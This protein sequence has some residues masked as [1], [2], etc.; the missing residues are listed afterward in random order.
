[1]HPRDA[2]PRR[3]RG[4][5]DVGRTDR[6]RRSRRAGFGTAAAAPPVASLPAAWPPNEFVR[7]RRVSESRR[8][9]GPI[10]VERLKNR[11]RRRRRRGGDEGAPSER[12]RN[13]AQAGGS[14]SSDLVGVGEH[15]LEGAVSDHPHLVVAVVLAAGEE[16]EA[17]GGVP[18]ERGDV[19]AHGVEV[20]V[21]DDPLS[22]EST[23]MSTSATSLMPAILP[24]PNTA[25]RDPHA[26]DHQAR[27]ADRPR[28]RTGRL[29]SPGPPGPGRTR[30]SLTDSGVPHGGGHRGEGGAGGRAG[31][32]SLNGRRPWLSAGHPRIPV[33][34]GAWRSCR[35]RSTR[36]N[37]TGHRPAQGAPGAGASKRTIGGGASESQ[38]GAP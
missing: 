33:R 7:A 35:P 13:R 31:V 37:S 18:L 14:R 25:R 22:M 24:H 10:H 3:R 32:R 28:T 1:M 30:S 5:A 16:L 12:L 8:P 26:R 27:F 21:V 4:G 34:G 11:N 29:A 38:G 9:S 6:M 20:D 36:R 17:F 15:G 19:S 2:P 23:P